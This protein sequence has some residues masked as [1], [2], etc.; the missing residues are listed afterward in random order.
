VLQSK[1]VNF[2]MNINCSE[3]GWYIEV[4]FLEY[5][6]ITWSNNTHPSPQR[7]CWEH[8]NSRM[9]DWNTLPL[10]WNLVKMRCKIMI[11]LWI[12]SACNNSQCNMKPYHQLL[13]RDKLYFLQHKPTICHCPHD[14]WPWLTCHDFL[15]YISLG[16]NP[17][18]WLS[19]KVSNN[20]QFGIFQPIM[21]KPI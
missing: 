16:H 3:Y 21:N 20:I 5:F 18:D 1:V 11:S 17:E 13:S 14:L 10:D 2:I 6:Q 7:F 12:L 8:L 4:P 9:Q 15:Y 19:R